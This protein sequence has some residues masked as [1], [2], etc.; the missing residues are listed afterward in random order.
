[1]ERSLTELPGG[2][3]FFGPPKSDAGNRRVVFPAHIAAHLKSH[4]AGFVAPEADALVFTSPTG[5]PLRH[6]NFRRRAWLPALTV[7]GLTELHFHDLRH[8][9]NHL[10]A[11]AGATLREMMDRVGH[12]S[13]RAALIYMHGSDARRREIA[14]TVSKL[15]R[16][17]LSQSQRRTKTGAGRKQSGTQ[18]A[19]QRRDAP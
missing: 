6:S 11:T 14:D 16:T 5:A 8:T 17:E 3:Y 10:T 18:R 4:L 19:R 7:A 2:G 15:V 1:M 12:S 13:T 9:G